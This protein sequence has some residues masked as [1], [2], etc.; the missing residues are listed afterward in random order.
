MS[1]AAESTSAAAPAAVP[2]A[3]PE[4]A[5]AAAPAAVPASD[6]T[7][8]A[9]S[10]QPQP[11][12]PHHAGSSIAVS[13]SFSSGDGLAGSG[14][15]SSLGRS[16]SSAASVQRIV[17]PPG[18]LAQ[19]WATLPNT[20]EHVWLVLTKTAL[21]YAKEQPNET[22]N[23]LRN[24]KLT[25][26]RDG[27]GLTVKGGK[28]AQHSA[29]V[30]SVAPDG[31]AAQSKQVF[32]GDEIVE[33]D[34]TNIRDLSQRDVLTILKKT[35][36]H[37][38]L[39]LQFNAVSR[40]HYVTMIPESE[41]LP[42]AT[43]DLGETVKLERANK[44]V[45]TLRSD[46]GQEVSFKFLDAAR[47]DEWA[48]KLAPTVYA[49]PSPAAPAAD[50]AG[51]GS[52]SPNRS[53]RTSEVSSARDSIA[54]AVESI[55]GEEGASNN[56]SS[57]SSA[58]APS[59]PSRPLSSMFDK[60]SN[61]STKE[62]KE[63]REAKALLKEAEKRKKKE[64][65]D[66]AEREAEEARKQKE[67]SKLAA[68][69]E[70]KVVPGAGS[71]RASKLFNKA[72]IVRVDTPP[73]LNLTGLSSSAGSSRAS[74]FELGSGDALNRSSEAISEDAALSAHMP[75]NKRHTIAYE[76]GLTSPMTP[77]SPNF[78]RMVAATAANQQQQLQSTSGTYSYAES[79]QSSRDSPAVT[80]SST[81]R[82]SHSRQT[83]E[84]LAHSRQTSESL[85][86]SRQTSESLP[87]PGPLLGANLDHVKEYA[88]DDSSR[89]ASQRQPSV[90][91]A[92][93]PLKTPT[94]STGRGSTLVKEPTALRANANANRPVPTVDPVERSLGLATKSTLSG[95]DAYREILQRMADKKNAERTA[96]L[97]AFRAKV[98]ATEVQDREQKASQLHAFTD[99]SDL[100]FKKM[101]A[102]QHAEVVAS[103]EKSREAVAVVDVKKS[104]DREAILSHF[105]IK[106]KI[107][108]RPRVK[109]NESRL[110]KKNTSRKSVMNE[111]A[112]KAAKRRARRMY[113]VQEILSTEQSYVQGLAVVQEVFLNPLKASAV[114]A[115]PLLSENDIKKI[116]ANFETILT[117]N[118]KFL[119]DF[120]K[121]IDNWTNE[122]VVGDV[123]LE[124]ANFFRLYAQYVNNFPVAMSTIEKRT[125]QSAAFREFLRASAARPECKSF[126]LKEIMLTP[127][128]RIPRYKLLL[129]DLVKH[130]EKEHPDF[131]TLRKAVEAMKALAQYLNEAK[132]E[133]EM[134]REML[135]ITERIRDCPMLITPNRKFLA[136]FD[137]EELTLKSTDGS[138]SRAFRVKSDCQVFLFDDIVVI[139]K[140]S[141]ANSSG[142]EKSKTALDKKALKKVTFE[143]MMSVAEISLKEVSWFATT[144]ELVNA[145][146]LKKFPNTERT[147]RVSNPKNKA[148]FVKAF[149]DAQAEFRK[150]MSA[151]GGLQRGPAAHP[152]S[153]PPS[154]ESSSTSLATPTTLITV[155][156]TSNPNLAGSA[157]SSKVQLEAPVANVHF[158]KDKDK[159]KQK[160]KHT[161][162]AS[163]NVPSGIAA[164]IGVT[165]TG[166]S[167]LV[168]GSTPSDRASVVDVSDDEDANTDNRASR[169]SR[170][171]SAAERQN[172]VSKTI[173][174]IRKVTSSTESKKGV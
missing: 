110:S 26:G 153:E 105:R 31:P 86:H 135:D 76:P 114:S 81:P 155:S 29:V 6:E 143:S 102:K 80:G 5:P 4:A 122:Q 44:T 25:K 18:Q 159:S 171:P 64:E 27:L 124:V 69:R 82:N 84:S 103:I 77:N 16:A 55:V 91:P 7:A 138:R 22:R 125:T 101:K 21:T 170:T 163:T 123:F 136:E 126:G 162:S 51:D 14:S 88:L 157:S 12:P 63:A 115:K 32:A 97:A 87:S 42:A 92:E 158:A 130:T 34:G 116:F 119:N 109:R 144:P 120:K 104:N 36:R 152:V 66:R 41:L 45:L 165:S 107:P 99:N 43:V 90:E 151:D 75:I 173:N 54:A 52:G 24:V 10:S 2:E 39:Q 128:Q 94:S 62:S 85:A 57:S 8:A 78:S 149:Q 49:E 59:T 98:A 161:R 13:Q 47:T 61:R 73:H 3:V 174:A 140:R 37:V 129:D 72:D 38:R 15:G 142:N 46:A 168:P 172:V 79:E 166:V 67:E 167:L 56:S 30:N 11:P 60:E 164:A 71:K 156:A 146:Q 150:A 132:R 127:I 111:R 137:M 121:R 33:V 100:D 95:A 89:P 9:S 96:T 70:K 28:D 83:S 169:V 23:T 1:D 134:R 17:L 19:G 160:K 108:S 58:A 145:F 117:L 131:D 53:R 74:A 139:T 35:S 154:G 48:A 40:A 133:A 148:A 20:D 68:R 112:Q 50:T 93:S 106:L 65:K 118:T 147:F 141:G 113:I